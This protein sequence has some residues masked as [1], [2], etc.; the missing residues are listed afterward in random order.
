MKKNIVVLICFLIGSIS[1]AQEK[2]KLVVG[3]VVDQMRQEYLYRFQKKFGDGGFKRLMDDGFMLTNAHY[4]YV[5]TKTAPGHASI[6]S[7]TSPAIHGIIG[8]DWYDKDL[9]KRVYCVK[10]ETHSTVGTLSVEEGKM[11]PHRLLSTTITDELELSTQKRSKVIGISIKER[12]AI[13][14]AGHVA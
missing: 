13:L 1:Y 4:N 14:S 3:I 7:G 10:D 8:N 6:Y 9:N 11:S 2:P 5:P 12:S